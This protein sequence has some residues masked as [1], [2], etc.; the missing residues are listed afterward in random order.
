[1]GIYDRDYYRET[2]RDPSWNIAGWS[3][4]T[5]LIVVNC[6]VF[7]FDM[8]AGGRR[9]IFVVEPPPLEA[10]GCFTI[11]AAINHFQIWRFITFQ[12][13]HHGPYHLFVNMLGLYF[14]GRMVEDWLGARR[15]LAYYLLSGVG[16]ALCFVAASKTGMIFAPDDARL[17]G[18]SA[19]LFAILVAAA[20]YMPD[21]E[22]VVFTP[23]PIPLP[24]RWAATG[25]ILIAVVTVLK[26][27]GNAGGEAAHLGGALVGYLL[28]IN[29][30]LLSYFD[31][32]LPSLVRRPQFRRAKYPRI[33]E[34]SPS[35]LDES[36]SL[37][38][39]LAKISREGIDS[40]SPAEKAALERESRSRRERFNKQ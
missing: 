25:Y 34:V 37:D 40:L 22:I 33:A 19:G 3:V 29:P 36:A 1:V 38:D 2:T 9:S 35:E 12:F 21:A 16:G 18:A 32:G 7:A 20:V 23:F 39:L 13:L 26:N 15:Y 27:G 8:L 30:H 24:I 4:T 17:V 28:L 10:L 31:R 5:W 11:D 14:F 6:A